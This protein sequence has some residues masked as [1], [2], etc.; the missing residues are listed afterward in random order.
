MTFFKDNPV[1]NLFKIDF[2]VISGGMVWAS[3]ARLAA[4]VSN[5]GGLGLIGAG[6]MKPELLEEHID[7]A[8]K[9]TKHPFGVNIPLMIGHSKDH[10]DICIEKKVQVVFTA[11]G[12]PALYTQKLKDAGITV[13]HVVPNAK[14]ALKA[15]NSG[16]DAVVAE[17]TEAGGHNGK[18]GLTSLVLWPSVADKVKIPLIAAGG[19]G[20]GRAMAAAFALGASGVQIGTRFA[21]S[22]ESTAHQNYKDA[23][24]KADG[25][26][27]RI[28]NTA[29]MPI[30]ALLNP[31]VN[32]YIKKECAGESIESL[33]SFRGK[34]RTKTGIFEG[35]IEDGEMD[36]GQVCELINEVLPVKEIMNRLIEQ[37]FV[38]KNL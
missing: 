19:I 11:A 29:H 28:F 37:F 6:S 31:Y 23:C 17:G 20:T 13:A 33:L 30:R 1:C 27:V 2:P 10:I 16:C 3:G 7:K 38:A 8:F 12:N 9:A 18:D 25:G 4:A 14:L 36:A 34:G 26:S 21:V 22:T 35:D 24:V 5:A 32:E 15:Q